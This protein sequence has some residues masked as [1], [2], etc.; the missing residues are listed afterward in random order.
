VSKVDPFSSFRVEDFPTEQTWIQNLFLP[1]NN[2]LGQVT[3][4]LNGGVTVPDNIP[5]FTKTLSGQSI[6]L[7]QVFRYEGKFTPTALSIQGFKNGSAIAL[8]A[9]WSVS[10]DTITVSKLFEITASGNT[11]VASGTSY[12]IQLRFT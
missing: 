4:A 8:V 12:Q 2:I 1:L 5:G 9:A 6:T 3:R 10:G 11:A 7:P